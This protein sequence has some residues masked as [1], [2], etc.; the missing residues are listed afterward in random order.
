MVSGVPLNT[1]TSSLQGAE[2]SSSLPRGSPPQLLRRLAPSALPEPSVN[3]L[4][5]P[6]IPEPSSTSLEQPSV[7]YGLFS[8]KQNPGKA[9]QHQAPLVQT[10]ETHMNSLFTMLEE[11]SLIETENLAIHSASSTQ[12]LLTQVP[13]MSSNKLHQHYSRTSLPGTLTSLTLT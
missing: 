6:S 7:H 2:A 11:P 12:G 3:V 9:Q 1:K 13:S 4:V 8:S 10:S 5:D